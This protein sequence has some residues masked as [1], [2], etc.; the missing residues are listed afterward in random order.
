MNNFPYMY[1]NS[2]EE[3][4]LMELRKLNDTLKEIEKKLDNHQK[5]ET[6]YLHKDNSYHIL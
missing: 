4:I 5:N 6:D 3:C 2:F 1:P